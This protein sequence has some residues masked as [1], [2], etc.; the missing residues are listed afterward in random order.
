[1]CNKFCFKQG[2]TA[3]ETNRMLKLA[4]RDEAIITTQTSDW[5]S[6][7]KNG[8]TLLMMLSIQDIQ[9]QEKW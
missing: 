4:F 9:P 7:F 3:I 1:M 6:M 8:V 2:K 5:F